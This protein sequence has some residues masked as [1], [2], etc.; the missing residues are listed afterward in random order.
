MDNIYELMRL[1]IA[2][3]GDY[4]KDC[5]IEKTRI[6]LC[7]SIESAE[8]ILRQDTWDILS[9]VLK[10]HSYLIR[11]VPP[12]RMVDDFSLKGEYSY[13]SHG[14]LNGGWLSVGHGFESD[15]K[16]RNPDECRFLPGNICEVLWLDSKPHPAIVKKLPPDR[17]TISRMIASGS[18]ADIGDDS[19]QVVM[20]AADGKC[21]D[22][23][24]MSLRVF[25]PKV[26]IHPST[27]RKLKKA[28]LDSKTA[29]VTEAIRRVTYEQRLRALVDELGVEYHI[30]PPGYCRDGY[31]S[32][33]FE[34]SDLPEYDGLGCNGVKC[35]G[36]NIALAYWKIE[37]CPDMIRNGLL[38]LLG[39]PYTGKAFRLK[40]ADND[41]P[42]GDIEAK[43]YYF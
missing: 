36:I 24:V 25:E 8:D 34:A 6:A 18:Y 19:Y 33:H 14:T 37:K 10:V 7:S 13:D 27:V 12:D 40:D 20:C 26:K 1:T 35:N 15:F 17:E 4:Y 39:R 38:R 21:I 11:I 42:I 31:L 23:H 22:T 30:Y 2:G 28:L 29:P 16:G 3:K 43:D 5:R 41:P 32:I 9:P